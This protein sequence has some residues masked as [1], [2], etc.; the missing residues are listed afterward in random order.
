M[1]EKEIK[2]KKQ[3]RIIEAI[4]NWF[5]E[6]RMKKGIKKVIARE[7]LVI[8]TLGLTGI[9]VGLVNYFVTRGMV[10]PLSSA[11]NVSLVL[12]IIHWIVRFIIWA[13]KIVK[14]K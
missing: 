11:L 12:Y 2:I 5:K 14:E 8:I 3:I 10:H 7:G 4:K 1:E 6:E 9:I 13:I